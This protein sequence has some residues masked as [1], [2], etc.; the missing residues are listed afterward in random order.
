MRNKS[1]EKLAR[2][3][4]YF[5]VEEAKEVLN[6]KPDTFK[7]IIFRLEQSGRIERVKKGKYIIIPLG[8][9]KGSHTLQEFV[10]ASKL[11]DNYA[12]AYWSALNRYGYTEQIPATVF[13]QTTDRKKQKTIKALGIEYRFVRVKKEKMFGITTEWIEN[14]KVNI[15]DREKTIIDCLDRPDLCG[16][17][18]EAAKAVKSREFAAIKIMEYAKRI[19]S[20][21]VLRRLGYLCDIY[22][23]K[24][25]LEPERTRN[26]VKLDPAMPLNK[27]DLNAKWRLYLNVPENELRK[28]E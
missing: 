5:T 12:I 25:G 22:G 20:S 7:K 19:G 14:E 26:Y 27:K 13:V 18:V 11:A 9:E 10:I 6:V 17:I 3:G 1:I 23:I 21:A 15:T 28:L 24:T 8:S 4:G 2:K 16:G